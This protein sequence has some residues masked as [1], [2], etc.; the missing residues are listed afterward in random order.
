MCVDARTEG[1]I[2]FIFD[3]FLQKKK[4][5]FS[6]FRLIR[7]FAQRIFHFIPLSTKY[8]LPKLLNKYFVGDPIVR[9]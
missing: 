4:K 3:R 8:L 9:K 7:E 2:L 1:S 5:R 6:H